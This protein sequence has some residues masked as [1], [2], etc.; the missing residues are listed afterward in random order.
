MII[1]I[2]NIITFTRLLILY[3]I[4]IILPQ[5]HIYKTKIISL[6]L[7]GIFSDWLDGFV[8]RQCGSATKFGELF[9]GFIDYIFISC[10]VIY[11]YYYNLLTYAMFIPFLIIIIRDTIRNFIRIKNYNNTCNK[12]NSASYIGKIS[13]FFQNI[14]LLS[15]LLFQNNY[16][17]FNQILIYSAL[18]SSLISFFNYIY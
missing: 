4:I 12:S 14:V 1:T 13:R 18:I 11:L 17:L 8:A 10:L 7:I 16:F 15:I 2:P 5:Y 6:Y 9:D 3:S